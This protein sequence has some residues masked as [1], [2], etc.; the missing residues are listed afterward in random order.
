MQRAKTLSGSGRQLEPTYKSLSYLH[1]ILVKFFALRVNSGSQKNNTQPFF[2][3]LCCVNFQ[4]AWLLLLGGTRTQL[5]SAQKASTL[6]SMFPNQQVVSRAE[7][8]TMSPWAAAVVPLHSQERARANPDFWTT[9]T[10]EERKAWGLLPACSHYFIFNC[11]WIQFKSKIPLQI[12][13]LGQ[14][15]NIT[16][17]WSV[18]FRVQ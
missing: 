7:G 9:D 4:V 16:Q 10:E 8:W 1:F 18:W 3:R 6:S 13:L 14:D 11:P 15:F 12:W 5:S 17:T 2:V